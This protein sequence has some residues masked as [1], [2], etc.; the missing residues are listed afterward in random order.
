V[1][2]WASF[3]HFLSSDFCYTQD[4]M[5]PLLAAS[6]KDTESDENEPKY[7]VNFNNVPIIEVIRFVSKISNTNFVFSEEDLQFSVTI[8]SEEPISVKNI[9]CPHPGS[10]HPRTRFARAGQ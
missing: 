5:E 8:V 6:S 10:T 1:A 3:I 4:I 2:L 9:I 7:T